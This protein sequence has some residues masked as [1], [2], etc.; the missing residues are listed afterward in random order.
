MFFII[1]TASTEQKA[2]G[3]WENGVLYLGQDGS[4]INNILGKEALGLSIL[5]K[6]NRQAIV[7]EI[8]PNEGVS[9]SNLWTSMLDAFN[10]I[11]PP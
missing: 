3:V 1:Y 7:I 5:F 8:T 11:S 4:K 6:S 2:L 10:K 9:Y